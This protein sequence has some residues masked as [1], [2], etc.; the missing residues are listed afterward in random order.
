MSGLQRVK[1]AC[2]A[3]LLAV[4]LSPAA[5]GAESQAEKLLRVIPDDVV[6]IVATS[7]I[8]AL[9][10]DFDASILGR[11]WNDQN[12]QSF[13]QSIKSQLVAKIDK[14]IQ[15]DDA[16]NSV[17]VI[18]DLVQ[19]AAKRPILA[20][21]ARREATQGP[22]V[23]A[24]AFLDAGPRKAEIASALARA[25]ALAEK[26]EIIETT[27]GSLKMH[28][29]RDADPPVYWGWVGSYL[30][31]AINDAEGSAIRYLASPRSAAPG[32]LANVPG[33]DDALA[34]YVDLQKAGDMVAAIV[35]E[36][37]DDETMD[38]LSVAIKELGLGSV[39]TLTA[40]IG[41]SGPEIVG[42]AFLEAPAPRTG[43]FAALR[44]ADISLLD[45]VDPGAMT[46]ATVN[47]NLASLYDT[48]LGAIKAA[49]PDEMYP[50]VHKAI[51]ELEAE[52]KLSIREGLL[53]SLAGPAVFYSLAAGTMPEAPTGGMVGI[54][55]LKDPALFEKTMQA[56]GD[57]AAVK[58]AG[59]LQFSSQTLEDGRTVH[60][61]VIAPLAMLQVMPTWAVADDY[62]VIGSSTPL[63][64]A[65]LKQLASRSTAAKSFRGTEKF[66]QV[67]ANLPGNL[68]SF[69]YVDS[70][71]QFNQFMMQAQQFWPM[72]TMLAAQ[73]E[74]KLP[75][76]LPSL[77]H[78]AKDM[79]PSCRYSWL[80]PKGFYMHYQGAGIEPSAAG[81]GGAFLGLG[82]LMPAVTRTRQ[83]AQRVTSGTNLS[84]IGRAC[85]IYA[86]DY[87][88]KLPPDLETL[89][90]KAELSPKSLE[91]PR[92]PRGFDGPS[93]IYI[94]G[95]T[96]GMAP[97]NIVAYENPEF[98]SDKINV[99]YLD[100]HVA[101]ETR[102]DFLEYL[103]ATY[104]RL[105][106]PMPQVKFKGD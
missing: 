60:V 38:V 31:I 29:P 77:G 105:G 7:G 17:G 19:L 30:V 55:K 23:C 93:Y 57:F 49:S 27:I 3:F 41:F 102:Q 83:I 53:D 65:G 35:R 16:R 24:F 89:V 25:E 22:P 95:Q 51:A 68:L 96:V 81:V 36:E 45:M 104:K 18:F 70:Q 54:A 58:S 44:P 9:K 26:G 10:S 61:C 78:I 39:K 94:A 88:D 82:I 59:T 34:V 66:R 50:E 90:E 99:L 11:I 20:G 76:V 67:A 75:A 42:D 97:G 37:G 72:L 64:S 1:L 63:C 92:K 101:A 56:V 73:Q 84:G 2:L 52:A 13:Y 91:S 5:S 12:T 74:I 43:L 85:L 6:G 47:C 4:V 14:E 87:E 106:R 32:Y 86:N 48:V 79:Q 71:V 40:R 103:E 15:D 69:A 98:C 46:A 100:S 62:L 8:D 33:G 21:V 80:G 28:A